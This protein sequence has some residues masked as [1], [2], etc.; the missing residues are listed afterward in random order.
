CLI[1]TC[2]G[3]AGIHLGRFTIPTVGNGCVNNSIVN[4]TIV[5]PTM[6]AIRISNG[7]GNSIFNNIAAELDGG[8]GIVDE[9]GGNY[10]DTVSNLKPTNVLGYFTAFTDDQDATNDDFHLVSARPGVTSYQS[11]NAPDDDKDG[12]Q[13]VSPYDIGAYEF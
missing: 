9:S 13:R 12:E 8:G 11:K 7:S 5:E 3:A 1:G 10:I 6:T 2:R 4:N